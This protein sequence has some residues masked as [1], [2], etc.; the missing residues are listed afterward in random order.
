MGKYHS[1]LAQALAHP[2]ELLSEVNSGSGYKCFSEEGSEAC[3]K[4]IRKYREQLA[5]RTSFED[6][7]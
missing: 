2:E 6:N 4:L 5:R 3:N 1:H 7:D